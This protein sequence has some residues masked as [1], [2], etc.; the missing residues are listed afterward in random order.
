MALDVDPEKLARIV[1]PWEIIGG[2]S[3][4]A[5]KA[6]GLAA[7]TPIAAG[8]G[9]TAAGALG[10]GVVKPGMLLDVAGT[11]SVLA[12]CT[13]Q[14]VADEQHRALVTMHSV[15][16]GLWNPL[17]YTAGGGLALRWFRDQFYNTQQGSPPPP[18]EMD[19]YDQMIEA[20]AKI[21]AGAEGL[22]FS[23]HL[24]GRI[25]PAEP[26]MRGA[27]VGFSWGHTQS[28]FFRAILEGVAYEYAYYLKILRD[29]LPEQ[30]FTETRVIG[31]GGRNDTWNGIK[32]DILNVPYQRLTR[33]EFSTWGC[34]LIAGHAVGIFDDLAEAAQA[35][36]AARGTPIVP[37]A[38]H[39]Q[40]YAEMTAKHIEWQRTF[41]EAFRRMGA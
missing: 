35:T 21:P 28:H 27:W 9:D 1:A 36:T 6:T 37:N 14:F 32:A 10:A 30:N 23:P 24:G 22:H 39:A 12:G 16:P 34:A 15:L 11:A 26:N 29:L 2:V 40:V 31:G 33:S 18:S 19:I 25:C 38:E 3:E 41:A 8:A 20:A 13:D 4:A 17:A 5:A 7:G